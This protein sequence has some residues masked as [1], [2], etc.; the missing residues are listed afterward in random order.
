MLGGLRG[1]GACVFQ[2]RVRPIIL[3]CIVGLENNL[4][5]LV[6]MTRRCV[7]NKNHVAR[8]KVKVSVCTLTLCIGFS[9]TC[10]CPIHYIV[11]HG[12]DFLNYLAK[13]ITIIRQFVAL[14]KHVA[15][16]KFKVTV[17][18]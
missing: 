17:H 16:S 8:S 7:A 14:E 9:K 5:Q 4:A 12:G 18:T 11:M 2:I 6:I 10:L 3:S 15:W 1:E 13:I